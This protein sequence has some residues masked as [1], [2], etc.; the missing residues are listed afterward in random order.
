[1]N[2]Q[3]HFSQRNKL[4]DC[5]MVYLYAV[6][7]GSSTVVPPSGNKGDCRFEPE[8][9]SLSYRSVCAQQNG[10]SDD[11][12]CRA[13]LIACMHDYTNVLTTYTS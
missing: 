10:K 6:F 7:D 2:Y 11:V 1:M 4:G 12:I 8:D 13:I 5:I 3:W 9:T